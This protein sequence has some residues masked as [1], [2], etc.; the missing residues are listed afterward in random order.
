MYRG[1]ITPFFLM[2]RVP[3]YKIYSTTK[4]CWMCRVSDVWRLIDSMV[5]WVFWDSPMIGANLELG[6]MKMVSLK[7]GLGLLP[8]LF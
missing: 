5:I 4:D 7:V 8:R 2:V 6:P 3:P 1:P